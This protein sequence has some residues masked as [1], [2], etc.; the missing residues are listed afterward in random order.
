MIMR[1]DWPVFML[2]SYGVNT[3]RFIPD[4]RGISLVMARVAAS[5]FGELRHGSKVQQ[6]VIV[7]GAVS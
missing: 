2:L 3:M 6:S 5:C 7:T 1:R 4:A